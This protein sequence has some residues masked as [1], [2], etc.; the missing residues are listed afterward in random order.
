MSSC[1][2]FC[3]LDPIKA[4]PAHYPEMDYL[5]GLTRKSRT[6]STQSTE[7]GWWSR[8]SSDGPTRAS[9]Q[10]RP[11]R[12]VEVLGEVSHRMV[13]NVARA[14]FN[15]PSLTPTFVDICDEEREPGDEGMCGE[16]SVS[17][18][19]TRLAAQNWQ[20]CSRCSSAMVSLSVVCRLVF[21]DTQKGTSAR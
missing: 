12:H 19:G 2:H 15:A 6:S 17:M 4:S 13:N 3:R 7:A 16:V 1:T 10:P 20:R 11:H 18:C 5:C 14:Y 8:T 9:T 21:S